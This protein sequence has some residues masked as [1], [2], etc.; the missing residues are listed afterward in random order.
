MNDRSPPV[1]IF[2]SSPPPAELA[3]DLAGAGVLSNILR[4]PAEL[5]L[6]KAMRTPPA[7]IEPPRHLAGVTYQLKWIQCGK[8]RCRK[9]HGPYWYAFARSGKR[10]KA[11][12]IGRT[13][14]PE[15]DAATRPG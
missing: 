3:E 8:R 7:A 6:D 14:P 5:W 12:Y 9:W 1:K 15:I 10:V 2:S 4:P 13:L 11:T